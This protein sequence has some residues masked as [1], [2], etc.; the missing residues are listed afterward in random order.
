[1]TQEL[2]EAVY[3]VLVD[4]CRA[5]SSGLSGFVYNFTSN[6]TGREWRFQGSLG[7]GG[8]FWYPEMAVDCYLEDETP[9]RLASIDKANSM[10]YALKIKQ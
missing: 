8:K 7:F 10:L 3:Q 6:D 1:M 5:N 9:D 4:T 2:A